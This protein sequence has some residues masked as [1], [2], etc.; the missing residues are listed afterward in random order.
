M[1]ELQSINIYKGATTVIE[2]DLSTFDFMGGSLVFTA[3]DFRG[4]V[5][6]REELK[7]GEDGVAFLEFAPK[8]TASTE[9]GQ[10][11]YDLVLHLEDE[12]ALVQCLPTRLEIVQTVGGMAWQ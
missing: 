3:R 1:R 11:R 2:F 9:V 10:G 12:I 8:D 4:N 5:F 7:P 6:K